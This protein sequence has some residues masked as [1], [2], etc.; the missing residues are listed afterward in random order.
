MSWFWFSF[1]FQGGM[2]SIVDY[3]I[4]IF[5]NHGCN[6][7][8]N[9]G[10]ALSLTEANADPET[11]GEEIFKHYCREQEYVYN[12]AADRAPHFYGLSSPLRDIVQGEEIYIN[13]FAFVT[14]SISNWPLEVQDLT[15]MCAGTTV[16]GFVEYER[17]KK[18]SDDKR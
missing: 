6:G 14:T 4:Q 13:Y 8:A 3:T 11:M 7:S 1:F 5:T 17:A 18:A 16:G 12:P 15:S 2:E 10:Y 9:F